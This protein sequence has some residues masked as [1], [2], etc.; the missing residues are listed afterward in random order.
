MRP[1]SGL[2]ICITATGDSAALFPCLRLRLCLRSGGWSHFLCCVSVTN[3]NR[4][5]CQHCLP[6]YPPKSLCGGVPAIPLR[7]S[8]VT[9]VSPAPFC[10]ALLLL[11]LLWCTV[12][13][14]VYAIPLALHSNWRPGGW[15]ATLA[16][17][18]VGPTPRLLS[19]Q[20]NQI[21]LWHIYGRQ[22]LKSVSRAK[23]LRQPHDLLTNCRS[24]N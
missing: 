3:C 6:L 20:G 17:V 8:Y 14:E 5:C 15:F 9:P 16:A 10:S 19:S 24:Q 2:Q 22:N 12:V 1:D 11:T 4:I 21:V 13:S 18:R 23:T 7:S